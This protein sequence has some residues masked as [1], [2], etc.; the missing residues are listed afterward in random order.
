[1]ARLDALNRLERSKLFRALPRS[2]EIMKLTTALK[3]G[4]IFVFFFIAVLLIAS[5]PQTSA[6]G[7][8]RTD[9]LKIGYAS[10][11]G[12][13]ISLWAAEN[14]GFFTRNGLQ[15]ELIFIAS[16]AAGIPALIAGETAI[17]SGSPE[18]AAQAAAGGADLII[19]ASNEPTQY[20]LIVQPNI[21]N[22]QELKG[23][24]IGIDRIGG[25]SHYATRRMLEKL[26]LKPS[27]VE[28]L[29]IAGGGSE[30][31]AAFRSGMVSAVASTVERFDRAKVPYH[32]LGD[33]IEMGI[34]V[35]G[36]SFMTTRRFRDQ[37]REPLQKFVRA[38]V[39]SAQWTKDPK[40][41]ADVTR[42]YSRYLRT[43]DSSV[44]ELNYK[45]YVD[46]MPFF[47][48]TNVDDLQANLAGL[49]ESNP[50]LR[51]LNLAEFVDN[52]FVRRVQQEGIVQK[53]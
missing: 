5:V 39:E 10:I 38:I 23:K 18:T 42:I 17:Y 50:K 8:P 19:I 53:R 37:N 24:R 28:F 43:Q 41:R 33:A 11:T 46:P 47:P 48:Y 35:I 44:L 26:G 6:A 3:Q 36:S 32:Y 25:S 16:S 31:V 40:N 52:S 22:A 2:D 20:K 15:P 14:K 9:G 30:R 21:K 13:R 29:S 4:A 1:M 27:D 12:N 49:A 34:R 51:D 7:A 45:L